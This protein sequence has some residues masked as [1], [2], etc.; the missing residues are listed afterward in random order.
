MH[1]LAT[2]LGSEHVVRWPAKCE[3]SGLRSDRGWVREPCLDAQLLCQFLVL[4]KV[5]FG[6]DDLRV[7]RAQLREL[8]VEALAAGAPGR[9]EVED[10]EAVTVCLEDCRLHAQ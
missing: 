1:T 4:L 2:A 5:D 7:L 3:D 9:E 6:D 8:G 10:D